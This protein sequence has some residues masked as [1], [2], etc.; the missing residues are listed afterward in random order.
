[1]VGER[2]Y[3]ASFWTPQYGLHHVAIPSG[4][5]LEG[6][7][8]KMHGTDGSITLLEP[9]HLQPI[10]AVVLRYD[11]HGYDLSEQ[12]SSRG[13]ELGGMDATGPFSWEFCRDLPNSQ[14][15]KYVPSDEASICKPQ[16]LWEEALIEADEAS[17]GDDSIE[18]TDGED[19]LDI[20]MQDERTAWKEHKITSILD[21]Y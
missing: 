1:M 6:I 14:R 2:L 15:Q 7:K 10:E 5:Q 16:L 21:K 20:K 3:Y 4:I 9:C 19:S 8:I 12:Y 18:L 11:P 17:I 13:E